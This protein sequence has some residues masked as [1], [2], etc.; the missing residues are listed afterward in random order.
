MFSLVVDN[1][2]QVN[3]VLASTATVGVE[4]VGVEH[5]LATVRAG[6]L[7]GQ[8]ITV[9][10]DIHLLVTGLD[11]DNGHVELGESSVLG[12]LD[13]DVGAVMVV[14]VG[15]VGGPGEG[16]ETLV[17][18]RARGNVVG[19][20]NGPLVVD[21]GAGLG[22]L[23]NDLPA[24]TTIVRERELAGTTTVAGLGQAL[25]WG[26]LLVVLD[27][28]VPEVDRDDLTSAVSGNGTLLVATWKGNKV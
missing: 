2:T 19:D 8:V 20:L 17:R 5:P 6:G 1:Q 14:L 7:G 21:V 28:K 10:V 13:E 11:I 23:T 18:I 4:A 22:V 12:T 16:K 3:T 9:G 26:E 24:L 25:G 15:G 27:L